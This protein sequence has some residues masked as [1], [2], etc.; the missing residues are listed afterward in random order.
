[1]EF[2]KEQKKIINNKPNGH[3]LIKGAESTGKTTTFINKIPSLLNNYCISKDD[4]VLIA[5][6][7]EECSKNAAFIYDNI[8]NE[9]YH[10]NSFFDRDN[11]DKLEISTIDSLVSYYF[12][13]YNR[14]HKKEITIAS[15][16]ECE[17]EL[18]EAIITISNKY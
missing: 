13:Q 5:T 16:V 14:D 10:Q 15:I 8:D 17:N 18:N 7:N 9:K 3:M 1:M 12:T 2:S 6:Y 4:K 11:S